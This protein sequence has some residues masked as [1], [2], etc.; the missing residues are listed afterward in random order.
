MKVISGL[1]KGRNIE[2]N[3]ELIFKFENIL[4]KGLLNEAQILIDLY[5]IERV[6]KVVSIGVN[7]DYTILIMKFIGQSLKY[8][9]QKCDRNFTLATTLRISIQ[10][11]NIL[12]QIHDKGIVLRY[13]K[14][15][16]MLMG[17]GGNKD[18]VYLIDFDLAKKYIID[19]NHIPYGEV[20]DI[21]GNRRFI[22]LNI[23]NKIEPTRR[24]DIESLGYN[25]VYFMKGKLPWDN[26]KS[27]NDIKEKKTNTSLDELC[28]GLPEEFKE[29]IK[30]ARDMEFSQKPDYEYL[31]NILLKAAEKNN[32][33]INTVKYDWTIKDEEIKENEENEKINDD[34]ENNKLNEFIK[35]E[36]KIN[37][38]NIEDKKND[39][40]K[41]NI[42]SKEDKKEKNNIED[43]KN[44]D[45]K[46]IENKENLK[47]INE[48]KKN[49]KD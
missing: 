17:S 19:G 4:Q 40:S 37:K 38:D 31:N 45:N 41:N 49:E 15:E 34:E 5:N 42:D 8:Y 21:L 13:L 22:S 9:L 47:K 2:T 43:N 1:Y 3:E 48:N 25:L 39:E 23:H 16:N 28:D 24:D 10:V 27:T 29:F 35:T 36:E 26:C 30:Y 18:Y 6:S 46:I 11:L 33:D 7:N 44:E 12:Q 14:P 20:D 32:I